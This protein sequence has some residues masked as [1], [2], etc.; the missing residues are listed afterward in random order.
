MALKWNKLDFNSFF[1]F[2]SLFS[3]SGEN[4]EMTFWK[5]AANK[6]VELNRIDTWILASIYEAV[7]TQT[8]CD[9]MSSCGSIS[10]DKGEAAVTNLCNM[11]NSSLTVT[12]Q[13][14]IM[15]FGTGCHFIKTWIYKKGH[16]TGQ[17]SRVM[18]T[19]P[20]PVEKRRTAERAS[21]A[22]AVGRE[23]TEQL[24]QKQDFMHLNLGTAECTLPRKRPHI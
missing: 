1:S 23:A 3:F 9:C 17:L 6:L 5:L 11:S 8:S 21:T 22:K 12:S 10:S 18:N 19:T 4:P 15:C 7:K 13:L 24:M 16:G 2:Y 14:H 20:A